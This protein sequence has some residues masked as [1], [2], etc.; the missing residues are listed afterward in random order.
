MKTVAQAVNN[1]IT[2]GLGMMTGFFLSGYF[3]DSLGT[4]KL[5]LISSLIALKSGLIFSILP[6]QSDL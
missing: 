2:Y 6:N 5:M 1:A 4:F 3:F